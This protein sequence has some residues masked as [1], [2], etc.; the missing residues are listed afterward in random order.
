MRENTSAIF[1]TLNLLNLEKIYKYE[2]LIYM[3]KKKDTLC[4]K[5]TGITRSAGKEHILIPDWYKEHS[6]KQCGYVGP[7]F[8]NNLPNKIKEISDIKKYKKE[9]KLLLRPM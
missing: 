2:V 6:R 9:I 3:F 4:T 1:K 7:I 8:Y 5:K